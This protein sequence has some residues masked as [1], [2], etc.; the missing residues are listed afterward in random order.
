MTLNGGIQD[1]RIDLRGLDV[2]V[3][4][5]TGNILYW[6]IVRQGKSGKRVTGD[7]ERQVLP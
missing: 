1:L 2:L 5:H 6:H 7:M 4:K 3:P